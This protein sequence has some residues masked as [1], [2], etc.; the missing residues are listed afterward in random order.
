MSKKKLLFN[1]LFGLFWGGTDRKTIDRVLSS[2]VGLLLMAIAYLLVDSITPF[3]ADRTIEIDSAYYN[4]RQSMSG[5][6]LSARFAADH[7][8]LSQAAYFYNRSLQSDP[9]NLTLMDKTFDTMLRS[10]QVDDAIELV[11]LYEQYTDLS[12]LAHSL[13]ALKD[14]QAGY[15]VSVEQ[16]MITLLDDTDFEMSDLEAMVSSLMIVWSRVGG[17]AYDEALSL[18]DALAEADDHA[19]I[20]YYHKALVADMAMESGLDGYRDIAFDSYE[21]ALMVERA[22]YHFIETAGNFYERIGDAE[23]AKELYVLYGTV[24]D[25]LEYFSVALER[26]ETGNQ[27][28]D[29]VPSIGSARDGLNQALLEVAR[30][31]F[32]GAGRHESLFYLYMAL[33]LDKDLDVPHYML[34]VYYEREKDFAS[35]IRFYNQIEESSNLYP[36]AQ[37]HMARSLF[38]AGRGLEAE[39]ALRQVISLG[40][41]DEDAYMLLADIMYQAKDYAEAVSVYDRIIAQLQETAILPEHWNLFYYRGV[42]YD[43]MDQ[44]ENAE[45]DLLRSLELSPDHPEALNYLA[46]GWLKRDIYLDRAL[47][48]LMIAVAARPEDAHIIDSVGWAYYKHGNFELAAHYLEQAVEKMPDDA[49]VRDHLGDAYYRM[50]REQEAVFE[51]TH[52]LQYDPDAELKMQLE[53]K[54][55]DGLPVLTAVRAIETTVD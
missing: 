49:V 13:L 39:S 54:L 23:R 20:W 32:S 36:S 10:G 25:S 47:E 18:L 52:A 1:R 9:F 26:I 24:H 37:V 44:W 17:G 29:L 40:Y 51:W 33:H 12:M 43:R 8:D 55:Q 27:V 4:Y 21:R 46:Y 42:N 31:L 15:Y 14:F 3:S 11:G 45:A 53:R 16:R 19:A 7:S 22:P 48:F 28:A 2:A 38:M 30:V 34:G 50:G 5:D 41:V 6:Y 35:A